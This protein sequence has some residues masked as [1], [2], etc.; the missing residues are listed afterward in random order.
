[1]KK[2]WEI[3]LPLCKFPCVVHAGFMLP[4]DV[5]VNRFFVFEYLAAFR[6]HVLASSGFMGNFTHL[7]Q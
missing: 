6:A 3:G 1:M 7:T 4:E 2:W 5:A